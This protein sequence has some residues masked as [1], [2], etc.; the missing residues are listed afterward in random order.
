MLRTL[1]LLSLSLWMFGSSFAVAQNPEGPAIGDPRG[2]DSILDWNAIALQ[3][4]ADDFS[5]IYGVPDQNG[6]THTS[7]ALAIIHLAMFDAANRITPAAQPYLSNHGP[8]ADRKISLDAAV[9]QAATDTLT[10][11]YPKQ[12]AVF[13]AALKQYLV[14]LTNATTRDKG[15]ALGRS[16][17][18]DILRVRSQDGSNFRGT[19]T[20]T[21]AP[22]NHD[23]D[24]WNPGQGFLDPAWGYVTPF[25]PGESFAY[26]PHTP[27]ALGSPEY[28]AALNDV[29]AVGGDGVTTST[30]RTKDQTEI[31]LFWAYDGSRGIGVP[32]RLYNQITRTIAIQQRNSEIENARLFALINAAM[33]DAGILCWGTKYQYAFWRPVLGIRHA[34]EDGNS[35]TQADPNWIPLGAPA[36]NGGGMNF[37][38]SFPA[39]SSGHATFGAALFR[40]LQR[41]YLRD[42]LP[43]TFVSDELNGITTDALGHARP[44]SP[45]TFCRLSDAAI[46]NARSRMYLGIHWQFD[47]DEGL[48][49]GAAVGD[50]VF[51]TI[52]Q[53]IK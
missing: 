40:T 29:K 37:T 6:P 46:E 11:L 12:Q 5:H 17:A 42:H 15:L 2:R 21:G 16:V 38:P 20:P 24:P 48:R 22:G 4:V 9:A 28:A 14:P 43:F 1:T 35:S 50:H 33:A 30:K 19:Y 39:Y 7:R 34:D 45:R 27:P 49:S 3:A 51:D 52:L 18:S 53:P 25:S 8:S 47:A 23:V 36:S 32:P 44:L 10:A 41:F 31:G 13:A 26:V